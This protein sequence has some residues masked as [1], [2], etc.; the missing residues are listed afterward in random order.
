M[1]GVIEGME[2]E[3]DNLLRYV[4]SFEKAI[5]NDPEN[6]KNHEKIRGTIKDLI[7]VRNWRGLV[8]YLFLQN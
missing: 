2:R 6:K 5:I 7:A 4:S 1:E 8:E 3:Y